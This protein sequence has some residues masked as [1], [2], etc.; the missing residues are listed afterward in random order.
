[1]KATGVGFL[2]GL[3]LASTAFAVGPG[4]GGGGN[5]CYLKGGPV[6]LDLASSRDNPHLN[7]RYK[8]G[9]EIGRLACRARMSSAQIIERRESVFANETFDIN[10]RSE[11]I[12]RSEWVE[13]LGPERLARLSD[14]RPLSTLSFSDS[15]NIPNDEHPNE[16]ANSFRAAMVDSRRVTGT[17]FAA[18]DY[19]LSQVLTRALVDR[20]IMLVNFRFPEAVRADYES[21]PECT[22]RNTRALAIY[23]NGVLFISL[24]VWKELSYKNR[25]AFFVHESLR[26]LQLVLGSEGSDRE[27][28]TLTRK[29]MFDQV[30]VKEVKAFLANSTVTQKSFEELFATYPYLRE[31]IDNKA[32][33]S[34]D[35]MRLYLEKRQYVD[36][37]WLEDAEAFWDW[38]L[39]R[40]WNAKSSY[41]TC[42][43][44]LAVRNRVVREF[45]GQL[46][47]DVKAEDVCAPLLK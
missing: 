18:V 23:K 22:S 4:E 47:K 33:S 3:T 36:S 7:C 39:V 11:K 12:K 21:T 32:L 43:D 40:G 17:A 6:L 45:L 30:T 41:Q 37:L 15:L 5:V 8:A 2:I 29:L 46:Q 27:L 44:A 31:P 38:A 19:A 20:Q 34:L 35:K 13:K 24:P 16:V 9:D 25:V 42:A 10:W 26:R 1:M 14:V 28:Q